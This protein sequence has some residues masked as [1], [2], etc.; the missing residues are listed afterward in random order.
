[1][2]TRTECHIRLVGFLRAA[3]SIKPFA[4]S[5][6]PPRLRSTATCWSLSSVPVPDVLPCRMHRDLCARH[7]KCGISAQAQSGSAADRTAQSQA[8]KAVLKQSLSQAA[9]TGGGAADEER[10]VAEKLGTLWGL[11]ILAVAYVHHSTCGYV[12]AKSNASHGPN[13]CNTMC[14]FQLAVTHVELLEVAHE[15]LDKLYFVQRHACMQLYLQTITPRT[16]VFLTAGLH[17]Q[18]FCPS[19][20]RTFI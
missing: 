11:L 5:T 10:P 14:Q 2:V 8:S 7:R 9:T 4:S 19:S 12:A 16:Q 13:L 1:M 3:I 6:K 18:R 20:P 17:C 15:A